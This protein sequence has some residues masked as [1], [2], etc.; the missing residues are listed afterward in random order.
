MTTNDASQGIA[1]LVRQGGKSITLGLML[2]QLAALYGNA[3]ATRLWLDELQGLDRKV[4][5]VERQQ[6]K[7]AYGVSPF[8]LSLMAKPLG[9][10][11]DMVTA[12][13]KT[14]DLKTTGRRTPCLIGDSIVISTFSACWPS[15]RD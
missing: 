6:Q 10:Q 7:L 4:V 12:G 8:A 15:N 11:P 9:P 5:A 14:Y 2:R 1:L 13:G 3:E